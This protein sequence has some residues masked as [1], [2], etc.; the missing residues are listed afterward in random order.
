MSRRKPVLLWIAVL[1]AAATAQ[2]PSIPA[3]AGRDTGPG[4]TVLVF[5]PQQFFSDEEFEP[6]NRSLGRSGFA[7]KVAAARDGLVVSMNRQVLQP[8]LKLADVQVADY[9]GLV[10]IGGSGM[11]LFWDDSLLHQRCR[12]FAAAGKVVAAIGIAPVALA[13][14]GVLKG[15]TATVFSDR[16]AVG[17]LQEH[18]AK[19]SFK[20]LVTDR[21]VITA[22]SAEHARGLARALVRA[23]RGM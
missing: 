3:G 13:R 11:A 12:E 16:A 22:A 17:F 18:G 14:A 21:K 20:P 1:A 2:P 8:D 5:L 10:L 7:L 4:R 9:A 19:Y 6:V 15:R 23:L